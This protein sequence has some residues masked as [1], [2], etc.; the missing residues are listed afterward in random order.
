MAV[1]FYKVFDT[2]TYVPTSSGA[3]SYDNGFYDLEY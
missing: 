2:S 1:T 3:A